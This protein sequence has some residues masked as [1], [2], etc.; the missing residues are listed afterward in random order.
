[1][2]AA[3]QGHAPR[4]PLH[5]PAGNF[6]CDRKEG[7]G[8]LYMLSRQRKLVAEY[9]G[10]TPRCGTVLELDDEDIEPLRGQLMDMALTAKLDLAATGAE[11]GSAMGIYV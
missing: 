6:V 2:V 9:V 4:F 3:G 1:V 5:F 11:A 8:T 7:L 10:G